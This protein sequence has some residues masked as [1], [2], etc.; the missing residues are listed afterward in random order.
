MLRSTKSSGPFVPL[1][2]GIEQASFPRSEQTVS[3]TRSDWKQGSKS[4]E[5]NGVCEQGESCYDSSTE[6][7]AATHQRS[8]L[9]Q[10]LHDSQGPSGVSDSLAERPNTHEHHPERMSPVASTTPTYSKREH[11][12]ELKKKTQKL[13]LEIQLQQNMET[14]IL[15]I[16]VGCPPSSSV[17][18][19]NVSFN[20]TYSVPSK[21]DPGY[22]TAEIDPSVNSKLLERESSKKQIVGIENKSKAPVAV[23]AV[24]GHPAASQNVSF[25][26]PLFL[27]SETLL[28]VLVE[29]Q[30]RKGSAIPS[31]QNIYTETLH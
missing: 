5:F 14:P 27:A 11:L 28:I 2:Q 17:S 22:E 31:G 25:C 7:C 26:A 12:E 20:G 24:S 23:T 16:S 13:E 30:E 19:T 10:P 1:S 9:S 4:S 6:V 21:M 8:L 18:R 3:P 29:Y 15:D